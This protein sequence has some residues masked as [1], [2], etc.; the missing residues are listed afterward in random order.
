MPEAFRIEIRLGTKERF[1]QYSQSDNLLQVKVPPAGRCAGVAPS[2]R[3]PGV[4][5]TG[6]REAG[7]TAR[8]FRET[9][10]WPC[11]AITYAG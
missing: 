8:A 7:S 1:I 9:V 2:I 6:N 5:H 4:E 3:L 11:R 10:S